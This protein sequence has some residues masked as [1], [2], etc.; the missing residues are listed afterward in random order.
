MKRQS[1]AEQALLRQAKLIIERV[2]IA[3]K[4]RDEC[5]QEMQ[6]LM[7]IHTQLMIEIDDL[8]NARQTP[9]RGESS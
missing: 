1:A 8:H 6:T 5:A 7:T 3:R 4:A 9:K 2:D